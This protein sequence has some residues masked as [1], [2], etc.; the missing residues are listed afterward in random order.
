MGVVSVELRNGLREKLAELAHSQWSGWMRY[1][2]DK[3]TFNDDGTWTMPDWAVVR[4]KQQMETPYSEL[5]E[6]EQDSDRSEAD[7]F[8][9]VIGS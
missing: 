6:S 7:K 2:F 9:A 5:S 4:W 3:G 8:L 1:L